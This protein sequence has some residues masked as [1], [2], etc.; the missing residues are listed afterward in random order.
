MSGRHDLPATK[1]QPGIVRAALFGLCPRCGARGLWSAPARVADHCRG[2]GLDFAALQTSARL[3][4]PVILPLTLLLAWGAVS[5][6]SWL[7]PPLWVDALVWPP[8]VA[9]VVIGALRLT[10]V[11]LL[12][13]RLAKRDEA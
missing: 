11:A 3:L 8:V 9:V 2:C 4:Y 13:W 7:R 10:R 6:D 1:G 5:L 12:E